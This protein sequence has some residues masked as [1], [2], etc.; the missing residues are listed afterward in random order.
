MK[1]RL[2]QSPLILAVFLAA[3]GPTVPTEMAMRQVQIDVRY[4]H[5][6]KPSPGAT[7]IPVY[8]PPPAY[9]PPPSLL[10]NP[11]PAAVFA[12]PTPSP[13]PKSCPALAQLAVPR[14]TAPASIDAA[15]P[16]ASYLMRSGGTYALGSSKGQL[17]S[18]LGLVLPVD[19]KPGNDQ[20][21]GAFSDYAMITGTDP[22]TYWQLNLRLANSN[23]ATPGVLITSISWRDKVRGNFDFVPQQPVQFL[24]TPVNVGNTWSSA[25]L[26]SAD[27]TSV[28]LQGS[29]P[30]KVTVNACGIP[31]DAYQVHIDGHIVGPNF[32]LAWVGDYAIGTQFG[33]LILGEHVTLN[34]SDSTQNTGDNYAYDETSTINSKPALT[35]R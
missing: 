26:D 32:Q 2:L 35:T 23:P 31:L 17:P 7:P 3:C 5:Q 15:P 33:G 12:H 21:D 8:V 11:V 1:R 20:V 34:G 22:S 19:P 14:E 25:G 30:M 18:V 6:P 28:E 4:G 29:I 16:K 9:A 10:P 27:Q 24:P 13:T